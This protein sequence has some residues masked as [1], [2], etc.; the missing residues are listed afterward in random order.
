MDESLLHA[1]DK[2]F[3]EIDDGISNCKIVMA[4]ISPNYG[5]SASCKQEMSLAYARKKIILPVLVSVL[6][7][8]PPRGDMGPILAGKLYVDVS[9]EESFSKNQDQLLKALKQ[10]CS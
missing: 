9:T 5:V 8:W 6:D 10:S 4:C 2:Y 3:S 1:G 7:L